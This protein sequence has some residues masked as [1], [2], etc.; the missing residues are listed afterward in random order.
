[1]DCEDFVDTFRDNYFLHMGYITLWTALTYRVFRPVFFYK[2]GRYATPKETL[3]VC[4]SKGEMMGNSSKMLRRP[5]RRPPV[6]LEQNVRAPGRA[7]G[8]SLEG[9]RNVFPGAL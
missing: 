8:S 5:V 7:P 1:M 2:V 9:A 4:I 6:D 3:R